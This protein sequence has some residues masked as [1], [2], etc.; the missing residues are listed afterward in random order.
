MCNDHEPRSPFATALRNLMFSDP[1]LTLEYWA[2][3]LNPWYR[4]FGPDGKPTGT[5]AM[6]V[7]TLVGDIFD[8]P[9]TDDQVRAYREDFEKN[10]KPCHLLGEGVTIPQ[11]QKWL[12][13]EE[14]PPPDHLNR[15]LSYVELF[16]KTPAAEAAL[17]AFDKVITK[18]ARW[19]SPLG[20]TYIAK[21]LSTGT[22]G[23]QIFMTR[24]GDLQSLMFL[25]RDKW[26]EVMNEISGIL[27]RY[28][29]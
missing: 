12:N 9:P 11:I 25:P 18:H 27:A 22:I 20:E 28:R 3:W 23:A 15:I 19:V 21:R 24:Y 26:E 17:A 14:A 29:E 7:G 10:W 1:K 6:K 4:H 16:V 5:K 13:D 2:L 8:D